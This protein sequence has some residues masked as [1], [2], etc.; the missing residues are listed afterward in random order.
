M[1]MPFRDLAE[2]GC[3]T[4]EGSGVMSD[5]KGQPIYCHCVTGAMQEEVEMDDESAD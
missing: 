2:K 4:C 5:D 3:P 1:E